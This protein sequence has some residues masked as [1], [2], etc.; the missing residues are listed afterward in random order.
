MKFDKL[1]TEIL[2]REAELHFVKNQER[3]IDQK[4][5][6]LSAIML[7]ERIPFKFVWNK[8]KEGKDPVIVQE[9]KKLTRSIIKYLVWSWVNGNKWYLDSSTE[10]PKRCHQV[11]TKILNILEPDYYWISSP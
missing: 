11:M 4:T 6:A 2:D 7:G 10:S 9:N 8:P 1:V 5:D 3:E